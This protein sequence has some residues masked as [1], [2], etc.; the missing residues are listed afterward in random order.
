M[1]G[2]DH[3]TVLHRGCH[4]HNGALLARRASAALDW[5]LSPAAAEESSTTRMRSRSPAICITATRGGVM[6]SRA[7][8]H[9]PYTAKAVEHVPG[10]SVRLTT[11]Q[12]GYGSRWQKARETF[13]NRFPLCRECNRSGRIRLARIVD[14][15]IPHRGDQELFW[16]T[17]NWQPLCKTCHDRKT[18]S[19]D[20]GFGNERSPSW[21]TGRPNLNGRT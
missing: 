7:P 17:S 11:A 5:W 3:R 12:R 16:D 19:E 4:M 20:G 10:D 13:L 8:K 15:V 9:R 14:H 21:R 6:P 2:R 1:R 18:A